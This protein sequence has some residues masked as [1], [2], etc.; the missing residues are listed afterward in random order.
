MGPAACMACGCNGFMPAK[1][2]DRALVH[3]ATDP[4]ELSAL[5]TALAAKIAGPLPA[6]GVIYRDRIDPENQKRWKVIGVDLDTDG[7]GQVCLFMMPGGRGIVSLPAWREFLLDH[8]VASERGCIEP[9]CRSS[10]SGSPDVVRLKDVSLQ[11]LVRTADGVRPQDL[12][13]STIL[14]PV[15][16]LLVVGAAQKPDSRQALFLTLQARP[17]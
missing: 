8:V 6:R 5:R 1:P 14:L 7:S 3:H 9:E 12:H 2:G 17:R 11:R 4:D 16:R 10:V 13:T 15:G